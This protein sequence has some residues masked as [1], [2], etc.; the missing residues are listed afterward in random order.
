MSDKKPRRDP[1]RNF[2]FRVAIVGALVALAGWAIAK[3]ASGKAD[4]EG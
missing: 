1:Y 3:K 4:R 2:N